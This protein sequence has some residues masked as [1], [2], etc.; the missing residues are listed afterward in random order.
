MN[1]AATQ[2]AETQRAAFSF[3]WQPDATLIVHVGGVWRVGRTIPLGESVARELAGSK[4]PRQVKFDSDDLKQWDSSLVN[5]V[6]H[7]YE[8]CRQLSIPLELD[9]LPPGLRRLVALAEAVP[10]ATDART[11]DSEPTFLDRTGEVAIQVSRTAGG[12]LDFLGQATI[13]TLA[14]IRGRARYRPADFIEVLRQCSAGAL[15]IVTL[16]SFLSG[17]IFAFMGAV[18]LQQFGASIYVADL[19]AIGMTREMG[20]MMT[21]IIMAG[22]TGA[23]FAA[24]LG[25]MKVTQEM[26]A[27]TT[28]G[29]SPNEFLVVPRVIA[30]VVMMPLLTLY[31]DFFGIMGG[32]AVGAGMLNLSF[33]SYMTETIH[34]ITASALIGGLV[35]AAVYGVLVA[36]AGCYQGFHC[37]NS[38]S[39]VGDAATRAV[40]SSIV[41]IVVACGIFAVIFNAL[42]I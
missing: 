9:S 12:I 29:I 18:Q 8:S 32:A 14:F 24:Q 38:S 23:A 26:D 31:A 15:G 34:A 37:G 35:K 27:L 39:A 10:E 25:T 33:A 3:E 19:V 1:L 36:V 2:A 28:M 30:L 17:T 4:R 5:F 13:A 20:A 16:I 41:A 11:H 7:A 40:V 22:R 21:A 42:G 6:R